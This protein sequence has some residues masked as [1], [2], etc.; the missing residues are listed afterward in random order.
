[1]LVVN[2]F[3]AVLTI[4]LFLILF[5]RKD[6]ALPNKI[7]AVAFLI[8]GITFLSNVIILSGN[9]YNF[10]WVFFLSQLLAPL[11]APLTFYYVSLM[12]GEAKHPYFKYFTSVTLLILI[13]GLILIRKFLVATPQEQT[14]FLHSL[15]NGE[16]PGDLIRY[17]LITL[18]HQLLYFSIN[19]F[20]VRRYKMNSRDN[21]SNMS[22]GKIQYLVTFVNLLWIL[23][24]IT[25]GTY[26]LLDT[27]IVEYLILPIVLDIIFLFILYYAFNNHAIFSLEEYKEHI[28]KYG[29]LSISDK[30]ENPSLIAVETIPLNEILNIIDQNSLYK[31]PDFSLT[32]LSEIMQLPVYKLTLSFKENETTFYEQVRKIRVD[33]AKELITSNSLNY[34]IEGIAYEVGFKNRA[35][36]YRAFQKYAGCDPSSLLK[37]Q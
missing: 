30:S 2:I 4:S 9:I 37:Q 33:K 26:L 21:Y 28:H 32:H 6:N 1:M 11:L 15:V 10:S 5:F 23:T 3:S 17:S 25:F 7:L 35:S 8:P 20:Q 13:Y 36:F 34:T 16:Y 29:N 12:T 24:F 19:V 14:G 18:F 22:S 31:E 27:Q